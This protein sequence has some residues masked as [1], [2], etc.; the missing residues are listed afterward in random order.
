MD[1]SRIEM[2]EEGI[3]Y[4][5]PAYRVNGKV[6]AGFTESSKGVD[7]GGRKGAPVVAAAAMAARR[8]PLWCAF[9][10]KWSWLPSGSCTVVAPSQCRVWVAICKNGMS[11]RFG[12]SMV[13]PSDRSVSTMT[14]ATIPPPTGPSSAPPVVVSVAP[15]AGGLVPEQHLEFPLWYLKQHGW[16]EIMDTGQIAITVQGIDKLG[17]RELS[18]P[19]NRRLG[20]SS[21]AGRPESRKK[22]S[23][24]AGVKPT[25]RR[26]GDCA[27]L[28]KLWTVPRGT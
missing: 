5:A 14:S 24:P 7:I 4:G 13:P 16:V 20:P 19:A 8:P 22:P 21:V 1:D 18:L 9:E 10:P 12:F 27:V 23:I 15:L 2:T 28:R 11:G 17:S 3:A 25:S 26:L 6:I